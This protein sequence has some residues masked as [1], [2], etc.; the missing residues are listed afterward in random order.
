MLVP[1]AAIAI[2]ACNT[3]QFTGRAAQPPQIVTSTLS[4]PETFNYVLNTT[5]PNVFSLIYDGL[6]EENGL[7][8]DIEPALA[9]S[10]EISDDDLRI[11]FTLRD[12]L[13][14]S[15]G[16][17]LT[18]ADVEF[19]YND[20]LFNEAIP[21]SARDVLRIGESQE[22]PK[23][24]SLDDRRVEFTV[25]E[26][27]AP[28]LRTVGLIKILPKHALQRSV[29][30]L[31]ADGT[32]RF[33]S[34]W[35]TDTDPA[36][37][38]AN[39]P[40]RLASYVPSQRVVFE[41]NLHYWRRDEQG[42]PMPYVER[43]I[44]QIVESSDAS[45]IQFRSGGLDVLGISPDYF[46]LLKREESRGDFTIY[47]G[48]PVPSTSFIAFN[49]NQG[50][51]N[52]VPLVDPIKSRWFNTVNFRQAVAYA[53]D[54]QRMINNTF[55][56]LAELQNSPISVQ[57]PYYLP[58]AEGLP[59]YDYDPEIARTLLLDAGFQYDPNGQLL[60]ADGNRVRFTLIT[61]S[62]NK[63]RE[64]MGAQIKQDLSKIG[65]QVDFNPIAFGTL[66]DKLANTIDWECYLL[67]FTG[68]VEPNDGANVW[69]PNGR[70]HRFNQPAQAGEP[71]IEGRVVSDW[72]EK[73]GQLYV[74]AARTL[75]EEER[76]EIYAQSQ[77]ITQDY[78]PFI[79]LV[80][81]LSLS[82]V[83]DRI[84]NV[85]YSALGGSLWNV[86]ELEIAEVD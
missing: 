8:A 43:L 74:D 29:D 63:I 40:Y 58:P 49:L 31:D 64:S 20:L 51:R 36:D 46:A 5:A 35:G 1:I 48:G 24:R 71:P 66:I 67:G 85:K 4:D 19:T 33:V 65:I 27:F 81:P 59:V 82:A 15:D 77:I 42:N 39:G 17:P 14:W 60:D 83:R 73:I 11:T 53:I 72:E 41:R 2:G 79:Y 75:D 54:R 37:I 84:Q 61:N 38:I 68:G 45:V 22:L 86:Y 32:P 55:Q 28:F 3:A 30:E 50:R 76:S 47:E 26:P 10:W 21:S 56:G 13:K 25:P 44:W 16:E 9:E 52:G 80:N 6:V 34:A 78:L 70:S 12:G 69:Q 23:V 18:A 62:G 7:T 57:S